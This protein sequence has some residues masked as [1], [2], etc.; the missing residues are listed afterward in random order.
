MPPKP[1]APQTRGQRLADRIH[2]DLALY[3]GNI[4][5]E[6]FKEGKGL[7]H[8]SRWANGK[9]DPSDEAIRNWAAALGRD[10][11]DLHAW[12]GDAVA[13]GHMPAEWIPDHP[14]VEVAVKRDPK[15][16]GLPDEV[17]AKI[18]QFIDNTILLETG[19]PG[20]LVIELDE[21]TSST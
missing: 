1:K 4:S 21:D 14:S 10:P 5:V 9:A 17:K 7:S 15:L 2:R 11:L 16:D 3:H 20:R 13:I 8:T 6:K 19:K 12:M 18:L